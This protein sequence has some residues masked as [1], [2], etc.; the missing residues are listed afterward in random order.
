[1]EVTWQAPVRTE[2]VRPLPPGLDQPTLARYVGR[3]SERDE[4]MKA[5]KVTVAGATKLVMVAGEPGVGKTRLV[6]EVAHSMHDGGAVVLFGRCTEEALM[7]YQP[8]VE[9]L[10]D[11]AAGSS[12]MQL[13]HETGVG[14]SQLARLLP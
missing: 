2:T 7:P 12:A 5:W 13:A 10:R 11:H 14:A 6:S 1:F 4:L 3:T 9:A 8:F